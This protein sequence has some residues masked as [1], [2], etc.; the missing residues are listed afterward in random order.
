MSLWTSL[1]LYIAYFHEPWRDEAQAWLVAR[2]SLNLWELLFRSSLEASGPLYYLWLWPWAQAFPAAF[3]WA[4]FWLSW[5]GTCLA[6]GYLL[7]SDLLPFR[8]AVLAAFG[9]LLGYEYATVARLYGWGCFFLLAG[10]HCDLKNKPRWANAL[11][12]AACLV[13]LNF[14]FAALT[15]CLYRISETRQAKRY[16]A[17]LIAVGL[18]ALH[19]RLAASF[20]PWQGWTLPQD[21]F[22]RLGSTLGSPFLQ[23]P[24]QAGAVGLVA[25]G[26]AL[27]ALAPRARIVLAVGFLPFLA[28]FMFRYQGFVRT[29]HGGA[30]F[31]LWLILVTL[32][33]RW[34]SSLVRRIVYGLLALSV[35]VG[36]VQRAEEMFRPYAGGIA[37]AQAI[38]RRAQADGREPRLFV[39]NELYGFVVA[40]RLNR[41]LW[42]VT[43]PL[44]CPFFAGKC[45]ATLGVTRMKTLPWTA[46]KLCP[47]NVVC[48]FLG[49]PDLGGPSFARERWQKIFSS[50]G[51]LSKEDI[52]VYQLFTAGR[53]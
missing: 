9:Y 48:F 12:S 13:Q 29:R 5:L 33:D 4:I 26:L 44:G 31:L 45:P 51:S 17:I 2:S 19:M 25:F 15:W 22:N 50:K 36:V 35:A 37:A 46:Q 10:V 40:A 14:L 52:V 24:G 7:F 47:D 27:V 8:V 20:L 23:S 21:F 42:D 53:E 11:L 16:G 34:Q 3:P 1:S 43:G 39:A 6:V 18:V 28:L 32:P 38:A 30:L 49:H 41:V